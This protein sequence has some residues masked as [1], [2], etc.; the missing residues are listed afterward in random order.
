MERSSRSRLSQI[1]CATS[2]RWY[3]YHDTT[4]AAPDG[5][6]AVREPEPNPRVGDARSDRLAVAAPQTLGWVSD[7][8][9]NGVGRLYRVAELPPSQMSAQPSM[10]AEGVPDHG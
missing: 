7:L 2:P 4:E 9:L 10:L 8:Q 5:K 1:N 6:R 3:V